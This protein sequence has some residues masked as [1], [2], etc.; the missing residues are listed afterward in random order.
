MLIFRWMKVHTYYYSFEL[1]SI[2]IRNQST[3]VA[4]EPG[5]SIEAAKFRSNVIVCAPTHICL[6][7]N[8]HSGDYG[9]CPRMLQG[10]VKLL[11]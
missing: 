3:V 6:S 5:A 9:K 1:Y 8:A 7:V 4:T 2:L 11:A 10:D